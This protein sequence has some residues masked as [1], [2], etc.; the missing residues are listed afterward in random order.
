MKDDT[1]LCTSTEKLLGVKIN[2]NLNFKSHTEH[3]ISKVWSFKGGGYVQHKIC[4]T[5]LNPVLIILEK[6]CLLLST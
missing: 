5:F 3:N 6:L 4:Y 2:R 1:L